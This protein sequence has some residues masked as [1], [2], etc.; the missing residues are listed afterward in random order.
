MLVLT[1]KQ[2]Q[3][4]L[5]GSSIEITILE[6]NGDK[7]RVAIDAPREV[8]ILRKELAE[9][10]IANQESRISAPL[11]PGSLAGLKETLTDHKEADKGKG[12]E[13]KDESKK[14]EL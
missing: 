4:F 2:G 6:V 9:A 13:P 14:T 12:E 10:A 7:V 11:S 1:R 5:L 3:S 8:S